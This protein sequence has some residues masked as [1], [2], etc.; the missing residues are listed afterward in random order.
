MGG[1]LHKV[2]GAK[3]RVAATLALGA[4][5]TG[6]V[7]GDTQADR[8]ELRNIRPWNVVP[9]SSP[10]QL[11][12]GFDQFCVTA[13]NSRK[14]QEAKLRKAGYVPTRARNAV[15][16]QVFLI[17]T[18]MPAIFVS[19]RMC[20]ARA[21]ARTGQTARIQ[22][23]VDATFPKATPVDASAFASDIEQAWQVETPSR[24]IIATQRSQDA[25]GESVFAVIQ[26]R[27]DA[28]RLN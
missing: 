22:G 11:E 2:I 15:D 9:L 10:S 12:R 28:K 18:R 21:R 25:N 8:A 5:T 19:D 20:M 7:Q 13:P 14:G 3:G 16:A 26:F 23:Y 27:P 24:A 17:D 1:G 6:C 4:L